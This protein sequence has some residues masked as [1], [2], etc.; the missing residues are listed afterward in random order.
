MSYSYETA[1]VVAAEEAT[2]VIRGATRIEP[3]AAYLQQIRTLTIPPTPRMRRQTSRL[4]P[5]FLS[6][7]LRMVGVSAVA[8]TMPDSERPMVHVRYKQS[9]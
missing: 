2:R 1:V 6:K 4:C 9:Y 5:K 7:D 3:R 8:L